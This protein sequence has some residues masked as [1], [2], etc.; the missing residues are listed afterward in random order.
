[1]KQKFK[2]LVNF[3]RKKGVLSFRGLICVLLG[4]IIFYMPMWGGVAYGWLTGNTAL[5]SASITLWIT[6]V[7]LPL[8]LGVWAIA[9]A[10][11]GFWNKLRKT[12]RH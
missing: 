9:F 12:K 2:Q 11:L 1:M 10:L 7:A 4:H 8:G 5:V 3:L 6:V